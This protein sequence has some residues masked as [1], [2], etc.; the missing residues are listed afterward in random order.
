M[1]TVRT[2]LSRLN[3]SLAEETERMRVKDLE[4][5]R[6]IQ[7]IT[8]GLNAVT[9]SV[10]DIPRQTSEFLL[11]IHTRIEE[12]ARTIETNQAHVDNIFNDMCVEFNVIIRV[13]TDLVVS[14]PDNTAVL[15]LA[16]LVHENFNAINA[17]RAEVKNRN[18]ALGE[19]VASLTTELHTVQKKINE[20]FSNIS[21]V[22]TATSPPVTTRCPV[23]IPITYDADASAPVGCPENARFMDE[24]IGEDIVRA[25]SDDELERRL[26]N[27]ARMSTH[28]KNKKD[29]LE[30]YQIIRSNLDIM[31]S[32]RN[33]RR[34]LQ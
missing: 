9:D 15:R 32:D 33:R 2:H 26:R 27:L 10:K 24:V 3:K 30:T 4:V 28:Y 13:V 14:L 21:P 17:V 34:Q 8:S 5:Q 31:R 20:M 22:P 18:F 11:H 25:F 19:A 7:N 23:Y 16:I 1:N 6:S 29:K 12:L